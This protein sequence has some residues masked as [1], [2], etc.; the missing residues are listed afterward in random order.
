MKKFL[1][2]AGAIVLIFVAAANAASLCLDI[3]FDGEDH[4]ACF[5]ESAESGSASWEIGCVSGHSGDTVYMQGFGICSSDSGFYQYDTTYNGVSTSD[6]MPHVN[7]WCG[8][9]TPIPSLWVFIREYSSEGECEYSCAV[10]CAS[11][12]GEEEFIKALWL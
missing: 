4:S 9:V 6:H 5:V 3:S 10:A 12:A 7:C 8:A 2:V 11:S 1:I